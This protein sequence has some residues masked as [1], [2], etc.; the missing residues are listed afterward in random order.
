M[1]YGCNWIWAGTALLALG[2]PGGSTWG[3]TVGTRPHAAVCPDRASGTFNCTARVVVDQ[4]GLPAQVRAAQGKLRNGV[5]P[6]YGPV[7]LLKA[8]NLT[9]QAASSHPIIAIVDAFDNSVVRADLTAYSEFYGIPDLPDCTVPVASS[10]VACFQQVD[11]R[12]GANYPPADTGWMLE[13]DLDVQVAHAICQNCSILLVESDDNTYNN[14]LAA[15]SEA[16]TL[17]AAVVSNSWS[18]AEWDGENLYDPY[19]AYPGVAMLFASGDS[20]Y[21]P[22]YPAASPYVTAVGGTTLHLYSDGS[23]MSEIAWRGTG[24]GCSAYEVKC[25]SSDFV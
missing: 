4:H 2:L 21:G 7:Q 3:Q 13:I 8:Y 22:Q 16:V 11:Q 19:V 14:M 6:P 15:V 5:A 24:S 20:G 12:G 10:N 18:S 1:K 25:I 17:G 9:G 23:Y